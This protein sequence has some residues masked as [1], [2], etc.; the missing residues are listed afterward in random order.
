MTS[1]SDRDEL[2]KL[3]RMLEDTYKLQLSARGE[4]ERLTMLYGRLIGEMDRI[5]EFGCYPRGLPE[6]SRRD[7][8]K[9]FQIKKVISGK[10]E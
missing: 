2:E 4:Y 6:E 7:F 1:K 3:Q 10:E 5:K 8:E 9:M